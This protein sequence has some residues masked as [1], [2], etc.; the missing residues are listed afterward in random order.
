MS[1]MTNLTRLYRVD[2]QLRA[3]RSRVDSA[4][5]YLR[6][7]NTQR[8][9]IQE[10]LEELESR[11]R[12]LQAHIGNLES[13]GAA[14]DAQLEKFRNDMNAASTNKQYNAV[15]TELNT[16]KTARAKI[17]DQI[18]VEMENVEALET[19]ITEVIGQRDERDKMVQ[20]A[21]EQLAERKTDVG[22][23][24]GELEQEREEAAAAI[25]PADLEV[26]DEVADHHDGEAMASV[27][28]VSRRHREYACDACNMHLPFEQVSVLM[29]DPT[30]MVRCTACGRILFMAQ[31]MKDALVPK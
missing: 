7:Q 6:V 22:E 30:S 29:G 11:K 18:L 10:R 8:G 28:E 2:S 4:E 27:T 15:L 16:V 21:T 24:V 26:F 25:S 19:E 20:H 31:D 13:E 1:L 12:H 14:M 3:L 5:R 17:D 23:R 9:Q